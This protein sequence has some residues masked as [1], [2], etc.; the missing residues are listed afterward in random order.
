MTSLGN[1][2][3]GRKV[4]FVGPTLPDAA[5]I[6]SGLDIR[7]PAIQGDV[8]RAVRDGAAAIGLVDGGFEYTAPVWHKE[9]LYALSAG[10]AV[11]GAASM[12]ALRAAEC[13]VFGMV[14]IGTI[15]RSYADGVLVD[16]ADVAQLHAP[17]ALGWASLSEPLVNILATLAQPDLRTGLTPDLCD[18]IEA[19]ARG[20]HFKDRTWRSILKGVDLPDEDTRRTLEAKLKAGACNRKRE[21][22]LLLIQALAASS[23]ARSRE[24]PDW[25]FRQ[26]TL[27]EELIQR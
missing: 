19:A 22:A 13:R 11:F 12:G 14:G 25:V 21:D 10:V 20:L 27:W 9:I 24:K 16:D 17:A 8:Y 18:R 3:T 4:L 6:A 7:P 15:A 5:R 1:E 23:S 26:T 2:D